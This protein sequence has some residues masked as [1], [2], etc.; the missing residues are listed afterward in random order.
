L[1]LKIDPAKR[2]FNVSLLKDEQE[3]AA[4]DLLWSEDVVVIL[5]TGFEGSLTYQFYATA[6]EM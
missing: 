6:R 2:N 3:E 4:V 1:F 5:P